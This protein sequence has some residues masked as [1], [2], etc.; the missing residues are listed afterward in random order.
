MRWWRGASHGDVI[1]RKEKRSNMASAKS[2]NG[3]SEGA[4]DEGK[5]ISSINS[6]LQSLI[7]LKSKRTLAVGNKRK[8]TQKALVA[9]VMMLLLKPG[10]FPFEVTRL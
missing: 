1:G 3:L 2:T 5:V 7:K 8:R 10:F 4:S 9:N 6:M